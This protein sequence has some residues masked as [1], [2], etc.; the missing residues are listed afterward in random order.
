MNDNISEKERDSKENNVNTSDSGKKNNILIFVLFLLAC[1]LIGGVF[2]F[3]SADLFQEGFSLAGLVPP[4]ALDTAS[5][6]LSGVFFVTMV[7]TVSLMLI[8]LKKSKSFFSE[9]DGEDDETPEKADKVLSK[10]LFVGN[11]GMI[12]DMVLLDV[13]VYF[14]TMDKDDVIN[15]ASFIVSILCYFVILIYILIMQ[16]SM[17]QLYKS[18]NPE[19][20]GELF[21]FTFRKDWHD[22]MDEGEKLIVYKAAYRSYGITC[23]I[24][25][26]IWMLSIGA[27]M[28]FGEGFWMGLVAAFIW[29]VLIVTYTMEVSRLERK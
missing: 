29:M 19:K 6:V 14:L 4:L 25:S 22:S 7:L 27:Q 11:M 16:R 1:G 21:S 3:F 24:C 5:W 8:S 15:A 12:A 2:G 26:F 9:W 28:I 17:V 10:G 13:L 23:R 18:N 20:R